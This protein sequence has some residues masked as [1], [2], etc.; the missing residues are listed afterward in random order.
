MENLDGYIFIGVF[1]GMFLI[2]LAIKLWDDT[3]HPYIAC[4]EVDDCIKERH[5]IM[6][7]MGGWP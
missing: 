6:K 3:I 7:H 5:E 4:K 2:F 1:G